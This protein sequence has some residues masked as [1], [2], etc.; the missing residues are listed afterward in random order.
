[1][2]KLSIVLLALLL[3]GGMAFAEI[4]LTGSADL[5]LG[6]DLDTTANGLVNGTDTGDVE[7]SFTL[8][9]ASASASGDA[10]VYAVIEM[11]GSIDVNI[12]G[13]DANED[14]T[15]DPTLAEEGGDEIASDVSIDVAKIV[16]PDWELSILG[17]DNALNYATSFQDLDGSDEVDA[18]D[19]N[20]SGAFGD[21]GGF[22]FTYGDY[23]I[24]ADYYDDATNVTYA[25]Y[26]AASMELAEGVT[27][28]VGAGLDEG[29]FDMSVKAAYAADTMTVEAAADFADLGGTL[30]FDMSFMANTVV[31]DA[32]ITAKAFYGSDAA[33]DGAGLAAQLAVVYAP[34]SLTLT[35]SGIDFA[36]AW[37]LTAEVAVDATEE[38]AVSADFTIDDASAWN[39]GAEVVYTAAD[40]TVTVGGG[41]NSDNVIDAA[42]EI[43]STT[44]IDGATV[45]LGYAGD[46]ITEADLAGSYDNGHKGS[47]TAKVS[48]AL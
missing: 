21:E 37:E 40:Y 18:D 39:T 6:Y 29:N 1:M 45:S 8:D 47:I 10:D 11:S 9:S 20:V 42:A 16:G 17:M 24:G 14:D 32:D 48:I 41:I 34:V 13:V 28:G 25:F 22:T 5:S 7:F 12:D 46:D 23:T 19:N 4:T 44:L 30:L 15:T 36:G 33:A 3:I 35:G 38:L 27:V 26:G 31:S 2:K 43:A